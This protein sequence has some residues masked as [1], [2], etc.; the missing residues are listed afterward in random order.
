M[1]V[2]LIPILI[3]KWRVW[4]PMNWDVNVVFDSYNKLV[5]NTLFI[6]TLESFGYPINGPLWYVSV[7]LIVGCFLHA[8]IRYWK[9]KFISCL[10]MPTIVACICFLYKYNH[11]VLEI[12]YNDIWLVY[13]RG[14]MEMGIGVLLARLTKTNLMIASPIL[15][16]LVH[17]I[18]AV[19]FLYC[20]YTFRHYDYYSIIYASATVYTGFLINMSFRCKIF[21]FTQK[22]GAVSFEM[23]CVHTVICHLFAFLNVTNFIPWQIEIAVYLLFVIICAYI[24][25]YTV[26]VLKNIKYDFNSSKCI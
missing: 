20:C 18:S 6:T 14:Y 11:G 16:N 25:K 21:Y 26:R 22:L 23:L 7:L 12:S 24:L 19:S 3:A 1:M 15:I 4:M 8:G 5:A 13:I 17:V 9:D 2:S 10:L